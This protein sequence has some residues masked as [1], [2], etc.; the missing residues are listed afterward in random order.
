[1]SHPRSPARLP[2]WLALGVAAVALGILANGGTRVAWP[3][4]A[5]SPPLPSV[6]GL[7]TYI[8]PAHSTPAVSVYVP[9][10]E[11]TGP[12]QFLG[13]TPLRRANAL[14]MA[15]VGGTTVTVRLGA[16]LHVMQCQG[17]VYEDAIPR[18]AS[19]LTFQVLAGA[20]Q[21]WLVA[22]YGADHSAALP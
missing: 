9:P 19:P 17:I 18:S 20:A 5:A 2:A 10:T 6:P 11:A 3:G 21:H 16:T 8:G 4:A 12:R 22:A 14:L 1:M 15:C 13:F 7:P